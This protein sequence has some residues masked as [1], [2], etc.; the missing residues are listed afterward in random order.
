LF[1][2]IKSGRK[3]KKKGELRERERE[4]KRERGERERERAEAML[5]EEEGAFSKSGSL[6]ETDKS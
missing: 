4:R 6:K 1:W 5:D 3:K 2:T